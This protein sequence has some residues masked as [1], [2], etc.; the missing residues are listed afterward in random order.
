MPTKDTE[1]TPLVG[2]PTFEEWDFEGLAPHHA[3]R[4]EANDRRLIARRKLLGLAKDVA[5]RAKPLGVALDVRSSLHN[6]NKFNG[7]RVNRLWSYAMRA[8]AEKTRLR[9]IV[10]ADLAK[11]L[12]SAYRNAYLCCAIEHDALEVSLRVHPDAWFDGQN[13]VHR[14]RAEGV[15]PWLDLLNALDGFQL[16][17]H[18][19]RGE[20]RCGSLTA[21]KLEE[22]LG[23][24]TPGEHRLS[25]ERRWPA[26][27]GS[28]GPVLADG[29]PQAMVE[30]SLRLLPLYRYMV[31][32]QESD[33][34]FAR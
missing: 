15:R 34:L 10:G 4:D 33:F 31:W 14:T 32:S 6:P 27:S 21:E 8:K 30:E 11:D 7:K 23:Y 19:W 5:K 28:R 16:R 25:I 18:D 9:K 20:W 13:L 2:S 12:N 17:M 29:V 22:F 3:T 24:Y 1:P 26:P